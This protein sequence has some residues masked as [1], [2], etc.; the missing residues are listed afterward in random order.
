MR[1]LLHQPICDILGCDYPVLQAGMGGVARAKLAAAVSDAGGFGCLG[2]VR[3]PCDLIRREIAEARHRT[4]RAFGV[5]LIPAATDPDLFTEQLKTCKNEGIETLVFFWDVM[6]EAVARANDLGMQVVYQVGSVGQARAAEAAGAVAI[7]AQG[8]EAGGHVHGTVSSLVLVPQVAAAIE[9]PVIASGGFATGR[10]LVAAMA[11]GAQGI[12]CGTAFL[13][14]TESFAHDLH[15]QRVVQAASDE[16]VHTDAFVINWP[17]GAAVRVLRSA[18]TDSLGDR[19]FGHDPDTIPRHRIAD[20]D[21]K[22]IYRW[23]T[24]SPLR[25]MQGDLDQLALFAG[26]CAGS[27]HS[28]RPAKEILQSI[29]HEAQVCV[30]R[31]GMGKKQT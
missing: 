19:L 5:N 28:I 11:L 9:L 20:E 31:N 6:P 22:P 16:T 18:V 17:K 4:D 25:S 27:I 13:A 29:L 14:A 24:D 8:V 12:H 30:E 3:E 23:S 2:M 10:G 1:G 26:Q 21:G 7:I 15:K